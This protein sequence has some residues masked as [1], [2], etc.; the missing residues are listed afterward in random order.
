VVEYLRVFDHVG[1][2]CFRRSGGREGET[3]PQTAGGTGLG[4]AIQKAFTEAHVG[5]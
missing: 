3:D 4:L 5:R 1:F 2:F